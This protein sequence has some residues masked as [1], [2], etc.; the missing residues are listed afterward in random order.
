MKNLSPKVP[1]Q[2]ARLMPM[3]TQPKQEK[4]FAR[5]KGI[6]VSELK[7]VDVDGGQYVTATVKNEGRPQQQKS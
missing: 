7:V 2:T 3:A 1:P 6:D 5:S 4:G